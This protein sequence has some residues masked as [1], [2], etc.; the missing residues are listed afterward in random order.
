MLDLTPQLQIDFLTSSTRK[1]VEYYYY[2]YYTTKV[3][4][5]IDTRC[6]FKNCSSLW[7]WSRTTDF[8]LC[9]EYVLYN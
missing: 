1:L 6:F 5:F 9:R 7:H 4:P 2:Y 8:A 3:L